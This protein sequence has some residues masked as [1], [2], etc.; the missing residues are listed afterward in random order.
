MG[1]MTNTHKMLVRNPEE[2]R[3]L[4]RPRYRWDDNVKMD[5]RQIGWDVVDWIHVAQDRNL[6]R[7]LL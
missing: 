3:H 5:L 2:K 1:E 6:N 7:D 4:G